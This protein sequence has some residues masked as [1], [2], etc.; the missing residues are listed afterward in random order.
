MKVNAINNRA[1]II[2]T[3]K[4]TLRFNLVE[5]NI[6]IFTYVTY[7]FLLK[8]SDQLHFIGKIY[9][10]LFILLPK[11]SSELIHQ[12]QTQ[13]LFSFSHFSVNI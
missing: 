8:F 10:E 5:H 12:V 3:N 11:M 4:T 13:A 1:R 9:E 7:F 6:I 2:M